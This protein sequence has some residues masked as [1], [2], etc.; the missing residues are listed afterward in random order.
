MSGVIGFRAAS[1]S[2]R[3][4]K[5]RPSSV[6]ERHSLLGFFKERLCRGIV[7]QVSS[8]TRASMRAKPDESDL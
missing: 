3:D 8:E 1:I 6:S 7:F 4:E 5:L 2:A